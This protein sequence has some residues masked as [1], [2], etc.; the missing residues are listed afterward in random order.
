MALS[1]AIDQSAVARVMG[2]DVFY[3]D[4]NGGTAFLLPQVVGLVGQ[5]SDLAVYTTDKKQINSAFEAGEIYGF[6]SPIHLA[7]QKLKPDNGV[8]G[9]GTIP[10]IIHPLEAA[11]GAAAAEGDVDG[12][13]VQTIAQAYIIRVSNID[14]QSVVIG[15]TE[16]F[17]DNAV[18]FRDAVNA[19]V[20]MPVIA[21]ENAG[22]L[23][24]TAKWSG[25]TGN[26]LVI[27]VI[28][29]ADSI[30]FGIT[31]PVGGLVNPDVDP[32]LSQI[33]ETWETLILNTMNFDDTVTLD[34]FNDVGESRW[35][36]VTHKP[37]IAFVGST[38]TGD[39]ITITD[40]RKGDRINSQLVAPGSNNLP[41]VVAAA[42][43]AQIA[44]QANNNPPVDYGS[45]QVTTIDAGSDEDQL[46]Y[47][48]RQ[49]AVL[50]GSST[51]TVK[52]G[53]VNLSDTITMF[54]PTGD[55]IAAFRFVVD[56]VK[57]MQV[58]YN[59]ALIFTGKPWDGAPLIANEDATT[60]PAA[61]SPKDAVA[62][63]AAM[64]DDL[65]SF[66]I[67][68]N[69]KDTKPLIVAGISET[70]AKRLDICYPHFLSGNSNIIS[71][72]S[73]FSFKFG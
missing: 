52:D 22:V 23:E 12:T 61:R 64:T 63:L 20:D 28:G 32:A 60:N 58:I 10:L 68:T 2:I 39:Q 3:Q 73:K 72:D 13:G 18:A 4:L 66:A 55:P 47:N 19:V 35:L 30:V 49:T 15:A 65:A 16:S 59:V 27:E 42:E 7:A 67:L 11:G 54:H 29:V 36:P 48:A 71:I 21:V 41:F 56:I 44:A 40:T 6:G 50:G 53:V 51:T 1:N 70:N 5:G 9:I 31:Q 46:D 34:K 14:S 43:L 25:V 24:L 26:D 69:P 38:V 62:E 57:E 8:G 37:F 17:A 45:A 33:G